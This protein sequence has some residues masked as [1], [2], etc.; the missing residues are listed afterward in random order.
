M[1]EKIRIIIADDHLSSER[2]ENNKKD[3]VN[4]VIIEEAAE[5]AKRLS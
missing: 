4:I 3:E 5:G 2:S 1:S